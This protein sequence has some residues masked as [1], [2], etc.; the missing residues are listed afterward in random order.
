MSQILS[1]VFDELN[2]EYQRLMA[3]DGALQPFLT[4]EKLC[5]AKLYLETDLLAQVISEDPTLLAA[6]ASD[7]IA[8]QNE[9]DNPSVGAIISSNIVMAGLERLLA[10]A[11][12]QSWLEMD[13][14][15]HILVDEEELDPARNYPV[16]ADY[17]QST[18]ANAN[19]STRGKSLLTQ[20]CN[21]AEEEFLDLLDN[22]VH[23][24]YQLAL[25]V[26]GNH[27]VFAPEDLA[28]LIC[29]NPLLLGLRPDD[30]VDEE[31]FAGDPPA[32]IIISGH[33]T[34]MLLDQLLEL[35]EQK[36]ALAHDAA[37]HLIIPEGDDDN[38]VIH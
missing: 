33:L 28:P 37:G 17:S 16:N 23:D 7:L 9:R 20:M 10:V 21:A 24:A 1:N 27:A 30:V 19:L 31:L 6:R 11:V 26:S 29:E 18:V 25:Q 8:D 3:T 2:I 5:H 38:P 35:A 14:E 22:E 32:G 15:G 13:A 4:A 34:H 12:E 36:G